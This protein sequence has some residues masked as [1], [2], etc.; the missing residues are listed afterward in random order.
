MDGQWLLA[1][2]PENAG[3]DQQWWRQPRDDAQATKVPWIIQDA[4]PGYHGVA[5]YWRELEVPAIAFED[6][7][8]LLRFWAVD[9]KADVWV[10]GIHV[11]THEG[12]EDPFVLDV[13]GAV[14][15]NDTNLLA[16]RVLN[17]TNEPIDGI[18]LD[19][20]PH[21]NKVVSYKPGHSYNHGGITD[22][23]E[24]IL[25]PAVR[26]EDLFVRPDPKTG[27][28]CI[29]I[30]VH[31]AADTVQEG[32]LVCTVAP[33]TAGSTLNIGE[34]KCQWQSGDN[35]INTSL[36][37]EDFRLWNLNDP[38]QYRVTVQVQAKGSIGFD[39]KSTTCGFRD[40]RFE[41]GYFRLNGKRIFLR[42]SH[43]GNH[44][45]IGLQLPHDPDLLRRD[46]L[47]LKVM[48]LNIVRFSAGVPTRYQLDLCDEIGLMVW[49]ESYGGWYVRDSSMA[50]EY[51]NHSTK[52]MIKRDRNHASVVIWGL[53]NEN[54]AGPMF[55]HAVKSLPMIRELDDTRMVMLNTGRH[56]QQL[57]IGPI[58][59]P[60]SMV[61]ERVYDNGHPYRR[62]P[63]SP[64]VISYYR[65]L[66]SPSMP[67]F[68]SE[69]GIGSAV[70]LV[71]VVRW[72]E[73]LGAAHVED[74]QFYRDKRDL[75][76]HDWKKWR[77]TEAFGRPEDY[78]RQCLTI[79]G[80][81]RKHGI[82]II[83]SNP[84]LIGYGVTGAVDQGMSGE[85]LTTTFREFKPGTIDAI[86]DALAPLRWCLF[87]EPVNVYRGTTIKLEAVLANEDVLSGGDYPVRLEVFGPES[88]CVY[89]REITINVPDS[90]P[91]R[92][93]PFAQPVFEGEVAADWPTGKY[94]FV[95]SF[96]RGGAAAGGEAEFYVADAKDMPAVETEIVLWGKDE[97]LEK[98]LKDNN[99][100]TRAF[101]QTIQDKRSVILVSSKPKKPGA[102]E[103]FQELARQ[104]G[105]G[106]TAVFLSPEV[107]RKR[108]DWAGHT[109]EPL[110]WLPLKEK[111]KLE[112]AYNPGIYRPD[113]WIKVHPIFEGLPCGGLL[114]YTFYRDIVSDAGYVGTEMPSEAVAGSINTSFGYWSGLLVSVHKLGSGKFVLNTLKICENLDKVPAAER[115]L[116]NMLRFAARDIDEPAEELPQDFDEYLKMMG[117]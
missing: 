94:R 28:I 22:S 51:F 95:A 71:R 32:N 111:G 65:T 44:C 37:L 52:G 30:N 59:N 4:F 104:I 61:W 29:Q 56:D 102:R 31:N 58:S 41:N 79:M 83:R 63:H 26:I 13:T 106:S 62:V 69:Y 45:P 117:L 47:N 96:E 23:V 7:Q 112:N 12:S 108:W 64:E 39:E 99:I 113:T 82:N 85:G 98:W 49:D 43:S 93:P 54:F 76:L 17:P 36:Q 97:K 75:F 67:Y 116:R 53:L 2:D 77:M 15:V 84:N 33:A 3:C 46:L 92:E 89:R 70:D 35:L 57:E 105:R 14:K 103:A 91:G 21:R 60:G 50:P 114:D 18:V 88:E 78:F 40:F 55:W 5:W 1:T 115:M 11:G 34:Q 19:K 86:F 87:V 16:V 100:R 66:G 25:A 90:Q 109:D 68:M 24:L 42:S 6:G 107:F 72:Y 38:Y 101:D 20:I 10:N 110:G 48:G 27:N 81:L 8:Y 9:Y 74:C 80:D 73:Q